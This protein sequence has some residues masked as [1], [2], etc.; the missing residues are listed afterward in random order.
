MKFGPITL[1]L[2]SEVQSPKSKVNI[3]VIEHR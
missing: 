2:Y 1:S 3:E